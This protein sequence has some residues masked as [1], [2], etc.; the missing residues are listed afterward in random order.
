MK[1]LLAAGG[2]PQNWPQSLLSKYDAYVGIDRGALYLLQAGYPVDLAVGDFDSLS[3]EEQKE[4]FA[5]AKEYTRSLQKRRY[6]YTVRYL[7]TFERY[8]QAEVTLIGA[9][10]GRWIIF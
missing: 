8:P 10:G 7:K 6:R 1:I 5:K 3:N 4:V 9:T 2:N